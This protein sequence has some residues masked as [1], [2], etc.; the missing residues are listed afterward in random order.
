[1]TCPR[2]VFYFRK[3]PSVFSWRTR[4][5]GSYKITY[6]TSPEISQFCRRATFKRE[7]YA[8]SVFPNSRLR[9]PLHASLIIETFRKL[10]YIWEFT[11]IPTNR[12]KTIVL[13]TYPKLSRR[14]TY[15]ARLIFH[16]LLPVPN[17]AAS[18]C[19]VFD[20]SKFV[21]LYDLYCLETVGNHGKVKLRRL[22]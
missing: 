3:T 4:R 14:S 16:T 12:L 13:P 6:R 9:T 1:M 7:K 10:Y 20:L 21:R 17:S 15:R 8:L 19:R 11:E 22:L 18:K 2:G 5:L